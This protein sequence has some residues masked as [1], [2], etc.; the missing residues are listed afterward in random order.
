MIKG[1]KVQLKKGLQV[2]VAYGHKLFPAEGM[3]FLDQVLTVDKTNGFGYF[4]VEENKKSPALPELWFSPEMVNNMNFVN[5]IKTMENFKVSGTFEDLSLVKAIAEHY[6]WKFN[7]KEGSF[8]A[9]INPPNNCLGFIVKNGHVILKGEFK[10]VS[11][12][13][14]FKEYKATELNELGKVLYNGI[15]FVKEENQWPKY[16]KHVGGYES[17]FTKI[18]HCYIL[19]KH[20]VNPSL[21]VCT[22]HKGEQKDAVLS[23]SSWEVINLEQYNKFVAAQR[24]PEYIKLIDLGEGKTQKYNGTLLK[25]TVKSNEKS[26]LGCQYPVVYYKSLKGDF[27]GFAN[28]VKIEETTKEKFEEPLLTKYTFGDVEFIINN[29]GTATCT[30]GILKVEDIKRYM[31]WVEAT[32]TMFGFAL[33]VKDTDYNF[34]QP[35]AKTEDPIRFGCCKGTVGQMITLLKLMEDKLQGLKD[36]VMPKEIS[37]DLPF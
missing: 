19:T 16:V 34:Y 21:A 1:D 27:Y 25:K 10:V 12:V 31:K 33:K 6:G 26:W 14:S 35:Y 36:A 30:H 37:D 5:N 15:N 13:C 9:S 23:H 11:S 3:H 22:N 24:W 18:G 8:E 28:E 29:N 7:E 4:T 2:G 20:S 17:D 32:P